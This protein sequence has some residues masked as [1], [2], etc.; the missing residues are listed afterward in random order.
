[1]LTGYALSRSILAVG[2]CAVTLAAV[3]QSNGSPRGNT[4]GDNRIAGTV[5]S[6][7]DG[8]PLDR[9]RVLL[10]DSKAAA[11]PLS[12]VT[13]ADGKFSFENVA[14]GKYS[15]V[16]LKGGFITA[17]YDQHDQY[18]TAIVTGAGFDTE[19][20]TLRLS[21]AA[22]I[23][24]RVLDEAGEP[25]RQA[26]V[27][28]YR[29][30]HFQGVDQIEL[31]RGDQTDDLGA[32]EMASLTPGTYFLA[33]HAQPWYAVHPSVPADH[34]DSDGNARAGTNL[35]RSLD[36]AYPMTY[37][38][39]ATEADGATPIQIRGGERLS[40]DMSLSPVPSLRLIFHLHLPESQ[41]GRFIVPQLEQPVFNFVTRL[42]AMPRQVS[43]DVVELTGV[44][45]GRY[46]VR[47]QADSTI[48]QLNGVDFNRDGEEVDT[49]AA[50][51]VGTVKFSAT[52]LGEAAIPPGLAVGLTRERTAL[53][54]MNR[55]NPK[56][57][58]EIPRVSAGTYDVWVQ[59]AAR[60][61]VIVSITADGAQVKGHSVTVPASASATVALT[62]AV[63][64][65]VQGVAKKAGKPFAEAMI[66]LVPRDVA[67]NRDLF[68][69]DQSD[70]DGTF[71]LR[72]VVPGS[73]TLIAIE[74]GW[75][76]DWSRPEIV[77]PYRKRGQPVEISSKASGT[78]QVKE[79]IEVQ[80]K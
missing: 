31:V 78:V 45:A 34:A 4:A 40:I 60:Q 58:T 3:G 53:R 13:S 17:A 74:N 21:P 62:L 19:N 16:G 32:Y 57:E 28:L 14:P 54:T 77:A 30:N 51:P 76:L 71:S 26:M 15:L 10:R 5:V 67:G 11:E 41:K 36:V 72:S 27:T 29:N 70:L 59:S 52:V 80:P 64:V 8:H 6:K 65:D 38:Q 12:T 63:G 55:L 75:D 73:Y 49:S 33:V 56:G 25:V 9:A 35:D 2:A 23:A 7:I 50:E 46:N 42:E 48:T 39:N 44:P 1:M 20:L 24:G 47:I 69:R 22:I 66:V 79:V 18:S 37:Y 68:R 43:P 61:Y